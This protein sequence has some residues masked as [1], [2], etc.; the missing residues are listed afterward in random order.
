MSVSLI[1]SVLVSA[2]DS[3]FP[4]VL[5]YFFLSVG[6]IGFSDSSCL[7]ESW[8]P[9]ISSGLVSLTTGGGAL[10]IVWSLFG[11]A[12]LLVVSVGLDVG[13]ICGII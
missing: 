6:N 4:F 1:S 9:S 8:V 7:V 13:A 2:L 12:V 11:S 10:T 3:L 5:S